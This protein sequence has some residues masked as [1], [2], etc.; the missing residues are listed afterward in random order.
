MEELDGTSCEYALHTRA[1]DTQVGSDLACS[2]S[3]ILLF[4]NSVKDTLDRLKCA[5]TLIRRYNSSANTYLCFNESRLHMVSSRCRY[6]MIEYS[7]HT[8][9]NEGLLSPEGSRGRLRYLF[10]PIRSLRYSIRNAGDYERSVVIPRL[11]MLNDD[12]SSCL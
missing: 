4:N 6:N 7:A 10:C 1:Q 3:F 2:K 11:K 8:P 12:A 5:P 9:F